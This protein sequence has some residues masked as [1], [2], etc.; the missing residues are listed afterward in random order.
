MGDV[1]LEPA[2]QIVTRTSSNDAYASTSAYNVSRAYT[3]NGLN[4]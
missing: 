1:R 3:A 2:H 4:Q